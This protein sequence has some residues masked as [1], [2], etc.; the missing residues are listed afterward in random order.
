MIYLIGLWAN[1]LPGFC[2]SCCVWRVAE[3]YQAGYGAATAVI[4]GL[5]TLVFP[6]STLLFSHVFTAFLGF[7]AF[8]LMLKE[9]DGPA[10]ARCCWRLQ[11]WR[12]ATPSPRSTRCS[13]SRSCSGL[14]LLSRRD[15]LTPGL[16]TARRLH[17]RGIVGII[18]LLLYNHYAFGSWTHL[19][20]SDVPRQ[21]KGFFGIGSPA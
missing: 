21:Q 5:G 8:T 11:D 20:Y 10:P 6:L 19:A 9:R 16:L 17:R 12:W 1:V 15:A 18:P 14:F 7:A 4:L 13:S 3:R 2:C